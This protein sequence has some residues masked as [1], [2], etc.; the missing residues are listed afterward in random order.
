MLWEKKC[1]E[2]LAN[3]IHT[4]SEK[5]SGQIIRN[6]ALQEG[7]RERRGGHALPRCRLALQLA[8]SREAGRMVTRE[9]KK[10][11]AIPR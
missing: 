9:R 7:H 3:A 10:G 6:K 11:A 8:Q 4:A 2:P 1:P 5:R